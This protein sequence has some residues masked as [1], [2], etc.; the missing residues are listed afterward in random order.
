MSTQIRL[1]FYLAW[2]YIRRGRKWTFF[3]TIF[4]MSVAF[5]NL[6]FISSLFAGI[7]DGTNKQIINTMTGNFYITPNDGQD[8]IKGKDRALDLIATV[9]GV[10]GE[11]A[12]TQVPARMS[13]KNIRGS[14]QILA[15]NPEDERLVSNVADKMT[16][17][18]FLEPGDD[19]QII[20][21]RQIAGGENVEENAFSFKG[22]KVGEKVTLTFEGFAKEFTIKGIFATKFVEADSRAFITNSALTKLL[23][24][25][26]DFATTIAIK[27][28]KSASADTLTK[29]SA[30]G[31]EGKVYSW[32][33]AAGLMKL[34]AESF[35]SINALVTIVGILIAAVTIFIIIYVDIVNKRKQIGILRAIGIK[36]YII[37]FS[38]V[39]LA[40]V[41]AVAGVIL[42]TV[43][44]FVAIVPY[45]QAHPFV[46]PICDA[47]LVLSKLDYIARAEAIMWVSVIS[48]LIPAALTTRTKILDAILGR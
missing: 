31:I 18:V 44:F 35:K 22:A 32:Q 36:S 30:L 3:L 41:Y 20:I 48:G 15:I 1:P 8:Y 19:D 7:I 38:Y 28:D 5:I 39:I 2:Q 47:V 23:P 26:T 25:T 42:G 12:R 24:T 17:G 10:T 37:I 43:L 16:S 11:S 46:L 9:D 14:W 29:I 4:M 40:A 33:E 6:I 27:T 45:F 34:V 13:Y 21:G